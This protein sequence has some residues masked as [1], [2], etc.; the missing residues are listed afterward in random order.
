MSSEAPQ[1]DGDAKAAAL[2]RG[3]NMQIIASAG[4]GKTEVLA[5]RLALLIGEGTPAPSIVA[6]TFTERA[7][8]ELKQRVEVR[9]AQ[10]QGSGVGLLPREAGV[11]E[12]LCRDVGTHPGVGLAAHRV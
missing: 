9:V 12:R 4:S 7:A 11:S 3:G 8:K 1:L 5:Q 6:F 2:Y 10:L